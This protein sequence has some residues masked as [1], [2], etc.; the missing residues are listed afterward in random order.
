MIPPN[1]KQVNAETW[2]CF[3]KWS[4]TAPNSPA[5]IPANVKENIRPR[6]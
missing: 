2:Y 5:I 4:K 3:K 1:K 6:K